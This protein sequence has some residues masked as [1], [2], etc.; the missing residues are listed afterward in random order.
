[1]KRR[2]VQ[3]PSRGP[4]AWW[5]RPVAASAVAVS[6]VLVWQLAQ[7]YFADTH[8]SERVERA[9]DQQEQV[10]VVVTLP[11]S[12]EPF[13]SKFFTD[14]CSIGQAD[15]RHFYLVGV[16]NSDVRHIGEQYW[17]EEVDLWN[18]GATS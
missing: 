2:R 3:S 18:R 4:R 16:S 1:M 12:P 5:I 6:F 11:F 10:D 13:H 15:E 7:I 14:C 8:V 17:V 9:L